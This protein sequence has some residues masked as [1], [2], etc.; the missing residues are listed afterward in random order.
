ME[1]RFGS[2][3]QEREFYQ[4]PES[5]SHPA[6]MSVPLLKWITESFT[7]EGETVL[8]PMCGIFTTA[9]AATMGRSVIGVELEEKFC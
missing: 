9:I 5:F 6:K 7:S 8:D 4:V 3:V 1:L 2:D